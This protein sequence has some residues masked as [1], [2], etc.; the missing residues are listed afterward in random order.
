MTAEV[1]KSTVI[2]VTIP[3]GAGNT[4]TAELTEDEARELY[5]Q[6]KKALGVNET[7][8][9]DPATLPIPPPS[10]PMKKPWEQPW[11]P[12]HREPFVTFR[13]T[14]GTAA[15]GW[16]Y[17]PTVTSDKSALPPE[18]QSDMLDCYR[19]SADQWVR[20]NPNIVHGQGV[21]HP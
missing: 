18:V 11:H 1:E 13:D 16:K 12:L 21:S 6:L 15:V 7:L 14:D 9:H 5:E 19:K 2:R 8:R 20:E 4:S 10:D 3:V 17:M